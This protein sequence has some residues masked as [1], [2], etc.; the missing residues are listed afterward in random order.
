MRKRACLIIL[1]VLCLAL[2]GCW[3][4]RGLNKIVFVSGIAVDRNP[5]S[6]DYIV[7]FEIMDLLGNIKQEGLSAK[8]VESSGRTIAEAIRNANR[9]IIHR[10]YFGHSTMLILSEELA[11]GGEL[12]QLLDW[13]LRDSEMRE[14]SGIAVSVG[15]PA[16]DLLR[17]VG[18]DQSVIANEMEQ[19]IREDART[20]SLTCHVAAYEA[21]NMLKAEGLSLVLPIFAKAYNDGQMVVASNGTAVFKDTVMLGTLSPLESRALLFILDKVEGGLLTCSLPENGKYFSLVVSKSKTKIS[22]ER[23]EKGR[24]TF[25]VNLRIS[26]NLTHTDIPSDMLKQTII[27]DYQRYARE[28]LKE[29]IESTARRVQLDYD[30]DIFGFGNYIRGTDYRLWETIR[31]DWDA[32]FQDALIVVE[33]EIIILNTEYEKS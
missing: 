4:Y 7:T 21:F 11:L 9:R 27:E 8:V 12:E 3:D 6:N 18:L 10:L 1:L 23:D 28:D 22:Y 16:G 15:Q 31:D 17:L 14:T 24:F 33:P 29:H 20:A 32:L 13:V 30:S 26:T 19:I 25:R 2:T 5:E